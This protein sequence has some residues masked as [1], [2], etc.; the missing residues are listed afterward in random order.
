MSHRYENE[1]FPR[2]PV[3]KA[4]MDEPQE[5]FIE[6]YASTIDPDQEPAGEWEYREARVILEGAAP[7]AP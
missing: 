6:P 7:L 2:R 5:E 4:T 1:P 3:N